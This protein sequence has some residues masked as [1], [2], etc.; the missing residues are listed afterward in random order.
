MR[1]TLVFAAV[2]AAA[3]PARAPAVAV[4]AAAGQSDGALKAALQQ[5]LDQYLGAR[6]K[7]EHLSAISLSVSLHG[8]PENISVT[9]GRM[10]Y[11]GGDPITPDSLWQIGSNTKA[12]TAAT[13]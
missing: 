10:E 9:A 1:R 3:L 2:L 5:D 11:G 6:S 13:I 4:P 12:F 8:E 7:I